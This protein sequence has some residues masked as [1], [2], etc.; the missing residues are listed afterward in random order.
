MKTNFDNVEITNNES[1]SRVN[2]TI[3]TACITVIRTNEGIIIDT[4]CKNTLLDTMCVY[5]D[6][7]DIV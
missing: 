6:E 5:N 3:G 4:Y 1:E 7:L 2:I